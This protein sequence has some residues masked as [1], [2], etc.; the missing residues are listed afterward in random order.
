MWCLWNERHI[1]VSHCRVPKMSLLP[2]ICKKCQFALNLPL[3]FQLCVCVC[4]CVWKRLQG[5]EGS[6]FSVELFSA[7]EVLP[8][9][10]LWGLWW[11]FLLSL[12]CEN[13]PCFL[14]A[15]WQRWLF[16]W[17]EL[18]FLLLEIIGWRCWR[19]QRDESIGS[20]YQTAFFL[21]L[22]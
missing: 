17:L 10:F 6:R 22:L 7:L 3:S 8:V 4:V 12:Y 21:Q 1:R 20:C 9:Y 11:M 5:K 13:R 19:C 14:F 16:V 15:L 18:D 2:L